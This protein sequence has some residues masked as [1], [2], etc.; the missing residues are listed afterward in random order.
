MISSNAWYG[1]YDGTPKEFGRLVRG[2]LFLNNTIL[3][4]AN[5]YN[6]WCLASV[7][8]EDKHELWPML[9]RVYDVGI[10]KYKYLVIPATEKEPGICAIVLSLSAL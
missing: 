4:N 2:T 10:T 5:W 6:D 7:R 1:I 8:I 3:V 9:Q